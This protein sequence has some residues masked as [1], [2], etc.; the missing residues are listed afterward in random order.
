MTTEL[1]H[2][3]LTSF[4]HDVGRDRAFVGHIVALYR[5]QADEFCREASDGSPGQL[6]EMAHKLAG[7]SGQLGLGGVAE[8]A[9]RLEADLV[10]GQPG[11]EP[12]RLLLRQLP[13][14]T[15]LLEAWAASLPEDSAG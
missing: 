3:A 6:A 14:L 13:H 5:A 11:E 4:Y 12:L 8:T 15:G 2:Q 1:D 7:S 9:R 10:A